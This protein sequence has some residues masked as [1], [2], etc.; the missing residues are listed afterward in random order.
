MFKKGDFVC[1]AAFAESDPD[2]WGRVL[3]V[4]GEE[5]YVYWGATGA[6]WWNRARL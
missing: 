3:E 1:I 6:S 2:D 4:K 5:V